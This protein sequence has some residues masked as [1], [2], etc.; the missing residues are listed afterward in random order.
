MRYVSFSGSFPICD[1]PDE[2]GNRKKLKRVWKSFKRVWKPFKRVCVFSYSPFSSGTSHM[3]HRQRF[4]ASSVPLSTGSSRATVRVAGFVTWTWSMAWGLRFSS[5]TA[6]PSW[7]RINLLL[8][9]LCNAR[10]RRA[11]KY[12]TNRTERRGVISTDLLCK[13]YILT[14]MKDARMHERY[15]RTNNIAREDIR[16][17]KYYKGWNLSF[18]VHRGNIKHTSASARLRCCCSEAPIM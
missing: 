1:L 4:W 18:D 3:H 2:K 8:L 6:W 5:V 16:T 14:Y 15:S 7:V 12:A 10:K 9:R 13:P 17:I 11:A